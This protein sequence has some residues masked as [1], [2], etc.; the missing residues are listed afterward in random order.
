[1]PRQKKEKITPPTKKELTKASKAL[2]KGSTLGGRILA[3]Q[4]VAVSQGVAKSKKKKKAWRV[5]NKVTGGTG[6]V[7]SKLIGELLK[8]GAKVRALIRS[9]EASKKIP[10]GVETVMGAAHETEK[11]VR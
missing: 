5:F 8:R 4:S 9:K 3:E 11:I 2:Q 6:A 7:G 1:M 10:T